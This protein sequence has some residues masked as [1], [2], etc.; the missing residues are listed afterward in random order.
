MRNKMKFILNSESLSINLEN[1]EDGIDN[2]YSF[3]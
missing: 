2:K 3:D 1:G